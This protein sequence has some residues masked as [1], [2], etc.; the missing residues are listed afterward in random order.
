MKITA[1][2]EAENSAKADLLIPD[3]PV[4]SGLEILSHA[5]ITATTGNNSEG[6]R[7]DRS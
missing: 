4:A 3:P 1:T 5:T 6:N 2:I 7:Q